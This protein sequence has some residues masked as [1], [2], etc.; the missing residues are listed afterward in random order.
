MVD[1]RKHKYTYKLPQ[2]LPVC[3]EKIKKL[4]DSVG[5]W[6]E[7]KEFDIEIMLKNSIA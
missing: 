1:G 6:P 7:R 4:Y 5:W 2:D 3:S